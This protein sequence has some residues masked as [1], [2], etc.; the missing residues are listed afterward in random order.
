MFLIGCLYMIAF[1]FKLLLLH[2]AVRYVISIF[3]LHTV[4]RLGFLFEYYMYVASGY[5]IHREWSSELNNLEHGT[6]L[7]DDRQIYYANHCK[8]YFC[9]LLYNHL[10][11]IGSNA[12][13]QTF[14]LTFLLNYYGLSR[15]GIEI[16][17]R[18]GYG[19]TLDMYDTL[20][21]Q[22]QTDSSEMAR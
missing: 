17:S 5:S 15:Q 2:I 14:Y 4:P 7:D 19:V 6:V 11:T 18:Y 12:R 3:I 1:I 13:R 9:G 8:S 10:L 21:K 22:Y 20:R 16:L